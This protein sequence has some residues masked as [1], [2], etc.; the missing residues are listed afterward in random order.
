[1]GFSYLDVVSAIPF[2]V[3]KCS[4][5]MMMYGAPSPKR[6]YAYSNS[7]HV[8]ELDVGWRRMKTTIATVEKYIDRH[9]KRRYKGSSKLKSTE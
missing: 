1:M 6:S 9:G 4:W 3:W 5:W 2:E 7:E 8:L